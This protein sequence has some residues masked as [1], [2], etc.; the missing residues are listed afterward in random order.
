MSAPGKSLR[1]MYR[2]GSNSICDP[3]RVDLKI[4][5]LKPGWYN[6]S[7]RKVLLAVSLLLPVFTGNAFAGPDGDCMCRYEGGDVVEGQTACVRT[8]GGMQLARCDR[9]LNNTSWKF[10]GQPCPTASASP[11]IRLPLADDHS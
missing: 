5:S 10:L 8:P 4:A 6:S 3:S 7:M 9:F 2:S 1:I 11:A